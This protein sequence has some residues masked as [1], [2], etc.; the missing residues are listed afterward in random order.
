MSHRLPFVLALAAGWSAIGSAQ[1]SISVIGGTQFT[2]GTYGGDRAVSTANVSV[3]AMATVGRWRWWATVPFVF[4]DAATV[5]TIGAGMLPVGGATHTQPTGSSGGM[6]GGAGLAGMGDGGSSMTGHAGAGDPLLRVDATVW[7]SA[8][9]AGSVALYGV[10][11]APIASASG[12]FGTGRWDQAAGASFARHLTGVSV[13]AEAAYWHIGRAPGDPYRNVVTGAV[14]VA[15]AIG[16]VGQHV[17]GSLL[18]TTP[19][20]P[21]AQG[22]VQFAAGW[23]SRDA[24]RRTISVTAG[25]G[26]TPTAPA[27]TLGA[28]WQWELR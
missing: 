18:A 23:S 22:P 10:V 16:R 7:G 25:I 4:Q 6:M 19:F 14:S 5:R 8:T 28:G 24:S 11:K 3:G 12:G 9:A 26:L 21:G 13:L 1:G 17:Y 20:V 27:I 2:A 15:R